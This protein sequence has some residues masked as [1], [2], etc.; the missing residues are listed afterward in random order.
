[1]LTYIFRFLSMNVLSVIV[2][3]SSPWS[4]RIIAEPLVAKQSSGMPIVRQFGDSI[5]YGYGFVMCNGI[6]GFCTTYWN[7]G[8][9]IQQ[10]MTCASNY[11]WGGGYRGWMTELALQPSNQFI[12]TTEGYQCGGSYSGQWQTN[13][14][15]HD[16]YPGFRTDQLVPIA[17]LPSNASVTLVHA[18]TNDFIQGKPLDWA[19]QN[20]SQIVKNLI[21]QNPNTTIYVA[22]IVRFM[23]PAASCMGCTDH[24]VSNPLVE[25]YN[26]WIEQKLVNGISIKF[27]G[28]VTIVDMYGALQ[29]PTDYSFDGVH[30]SPAGYQKMACSWIRGIKK[31]ASLPQSPCSGF[32]FG[33]TKSQIIPSESDLQKSLPSPELMNRIYHP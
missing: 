16:G 17:L 15:S 22:K 8:G 14:M 18:G 7:N 32:T 12:F 33:E 27:S 21:Q 1:M 3:F 29:L 28:Q 2:F 6:P 23:K 4:T 5:T 31:M 25:K 10:C 13:S 30:P 9:H 20:L 24:T 11:L 19:T 26:E